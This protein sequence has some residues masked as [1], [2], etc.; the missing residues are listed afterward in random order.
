MHGAGPIRCKEEKS[1]C[2]SV[3]KDEREM[4][5]SDRDRFK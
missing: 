2:E 4:K 5:G 3:C 1:K